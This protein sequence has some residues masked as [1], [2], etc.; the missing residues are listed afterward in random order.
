MYFLAFLL[1]Y[2]NRLLTI[3][4]IVVKR[5]SVFKNLIWRK[6]EEMKNETDRWRKWKSVFAI[7]FIA[8][9]ATAIYLTIDTYI[10]HH[11]ILNEDPWIPVFTYLIMGGWTG[12][13]CFWVFNKIIKSFTAWGVINWSTVKDYK[14]F[15]IGCRKSQL[16]ALTTGSLGAISTFFCLI[17]NKTLDASLVTAFNGVSIFYLAFIDSRRKKVNIKTLGIP[18]ILIIVGSFAAS[19]SGG[20]V[21]TLFGLAIMLLGRDTTYALDNTVQN[22]VVNR[23]E[24]DD[25]SAHRQSFGTRSLNRFLSYWQYGKDDS[26]IHLLN[27]NFWR[28]LWLSLSA[29]IVIIGITAWNNTLPVLLGLIGQIWL[30]AIPWIFCSMLFVFIS[31]TLTLK[32]YSMVSSTAK[33]QMIIS[34]QIAV[35]IPIALVFDQ[36]SRGSVG[37]IPSDPYIW[38][39]R[40]LGIVLMTIATAYLVR[41]TE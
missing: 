40:G 27:F 25:P 41:K 13:I 26:Q 29:T 3:F 4:F 21:F 2:Y 36:V 7:A 33:V 14:G 15:S 24:G 20:F 38:L 32:A 31:L 18:L 11:V 28:F 30:K 23:K 1:L 5:N 22:V 8:A 6:R 39:V 10:M 16:F 19:V 9:V 34:L 12:T 37:T 17:G 35:G